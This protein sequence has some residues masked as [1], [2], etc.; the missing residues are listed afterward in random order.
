[1]TQTFVDRFPSYIGML[2]RNIETDEGCT[3]KTFSSSV[4]AV[5]VRVK[6]QNFKKEH[7]LVE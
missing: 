7:E 6:R 4:G 5:L 2:L 1:M 3:V